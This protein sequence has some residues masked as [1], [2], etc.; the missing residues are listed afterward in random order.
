[1]I[2]PDCLEAYEF[3]EFNVNPETL[4]HRGVFK[5]SCCDSLIFPEALTREMLWEDDIED[6]LRISRLFHMRR[7]LG[8]DVKPPMVKIG[9]IK[10]ETRHLERYIRHFSEQSLRHLK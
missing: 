3:V 6:R 2:C 1:M 4:E 8:K 5:C 10:L 9:T 7:A